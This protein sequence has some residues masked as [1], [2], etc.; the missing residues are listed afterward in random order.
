MG[1]EFEL[2]YSAT[3][4]ALAA[5]RREL[6]ADWQTIAMETTYYD[7]P[8][9]RLSQ[10]H[11][12]LRRRLENGVSVCTLKTPVSGGGRGEWEVVC[13]TVEAAIPE[14]CKLG[15]PARLLLLTAEGV[16][17]S[18]GARFTRQAAAVELDGTLL[19]IAL[20]RGILFGG[21][22]ELPLCE[23]EVELKSGSE[24]TAVRFARELAGQYGLTPEPRSKVRRATELTKG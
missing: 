15:A 22:R 18:C 4:E 20:D 14:L 1:Y 17:P 8:R 3:E 16:A 10:L 2:K 7:D 9:H 23:L 11:Y 13:D 5:V 24:D 12:T 19:E 6:C 21:E